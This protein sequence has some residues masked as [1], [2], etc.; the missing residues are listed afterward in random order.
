MEIEINNYKFFKIAKA[1]NIGCKRFFVLL[2][3]FFANAGYAQQKWESKFIKLKKDGRLQYVPDEQG[4]VIPDFSKVGYHQNAKQI[5]NVKVVVTIA[6]TGVDDQQKIQNAIDELSKKPTDANGIRGAILLKKGEY[7]IPG[8]INIST[9]GIVLRGEGDDTKLIATGRGKRTTIKVSGNGN[10]KEMPN[11]RVKISAKYVPVGAKSLQLT[12]ASGFKVGDKIIVFRPGNAKWIHDL[13]MDQI[14]EKEGLVQW[15]AESYDLDFERVITAINGNTIFLDN[16]IVMAMEEQYGGGEVYKYNFDGRIAEVGVENMLLESEFESDIDEEHGWDAIS[17]GKVENSWIS[18]VTSRYFGYSCVNLSNASKQITVKD[19]KSLAPKSQI[20]GGRR[21]S[22]NNDGQLNLFMNCFASEGRHDY[23]TGAK[24][25]GPNVF[26]NCTSV[27]AKAD[28]GPHHRW[29]TG[30]LYD[31]IVTDG[32]I[33]IQDRGD[34]GTGH[35]WAGVN[36]VLWNCTAAKAAV[37]NPYV[38]GKNYAIGLKA[39]KYEG[40]LKGRPDG[41]WEGQN[42]SGLNPSSLYLKQVEENKNR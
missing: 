7:K 9:S 42:Q 1:I 21:Y 13:K 6:A 40:R 4:N 28:I 14:A 11:T 32:E 27:N 12:N 10:L 24:V 35:G 26:Y 22:F 36:Q 19:C 38:S 25:R 23:V 3:M 34:W 2:L 18:G 30:T 31:N 33:N 5:P 41:V 37:Q 17:F 20:I 29:A 8:S 39:Q 15:K 16:P